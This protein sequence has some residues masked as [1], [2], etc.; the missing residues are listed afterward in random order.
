MGSGSGGGGGGGGGSSGGPGY[1]VTGGAGGGSRLVSRTKNG[2]GEAFNKLLSGPPKEYYMAIFASNLVLELYQALLDVSVALCV[3]RDWQAIQDTYKVSANPGCLMQLKDAMVQMHGG[4]SADPRV[5]EVCLEALESFFIF[6][7]GN[8]PVTYA[9]A[10]ADKIFQKVNRKVLV[11][12]RSSYFLREIINEVAKRQSAEL[13][14]EMRNNLHKYSLER[15]DVIV[16]DFEKRFKAQD[17]K[18]T[19]NRIFEIIRENPEWFLNLFKK[20]GS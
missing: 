1:S 3:N 19:H 14:Y 18:M 8:S 15:A 6:A 4:D 12:S 10:D 13:T 9:Q 2:I 20:G 17:P 7:I 11:E 16:A 5:R